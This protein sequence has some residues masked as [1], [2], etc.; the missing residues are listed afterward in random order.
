MSSC[1]DELPLIFTN[2]YQIQMV[3]AA[4]SGLYA[5]ILGVPFMNI[6]QTAGGVYRAINKQKYSAIFISGSYYLVGFTLTLI[7][8]FVYD[9]KNNL[10][11]GIVSIWFGWCVANICGSILLETFYKCC[12]DWNVILEDANERIDANTTLIKTSKRTD[13]GSTK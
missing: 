2:K 6:L 4:I 7:L 9:S 5:V 12:I 3:D 11:Y 13:Y 1:V 10:I 8:L